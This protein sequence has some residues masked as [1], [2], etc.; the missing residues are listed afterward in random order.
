[1]LRAPFRAVVTA[2][3]LLA[4]APASAWAAKATLSP[5]TLFLPI[6]GLQLPVAVSGE[7][8]YTV[9]GGQAD[10]DG[11]L[12]ADLAAAQQQS[13]A[14]LAALFDRRQPCGERLAVRDGKLGARAAALSVTATVDYGRTACIA[15]QEVK[16]LPRALYDVEML[17]HPVVSARSLRMQAEVLTLRRRDGALP[18][19]IDTALRD[20]LGSLIGQRIGELFPNA[21]PDALM[22]QSLSFDEEVPGRLAAKLRASGSI[23]RT[24]LDQLV[25]R[26]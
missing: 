25:E 7:L 13:T 19:T 12:A 14:L 6:A 20:L 9:R 1:M 11:R 4:L 8:L 16:I 10:I 21:V 24:A 3:S 26:R 22:L 2:A 17:L 5:R 18:A 15:G 23:S